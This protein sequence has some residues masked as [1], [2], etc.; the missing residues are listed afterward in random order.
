MGL[1]WVAHCG[2]RFVAMGV[3]LGFA[4]RGFDVCGVDGRSLRSEGGVPC[5]LTPKCKRSYQYNS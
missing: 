3:G 1:P 5:L 2:S 4:Y